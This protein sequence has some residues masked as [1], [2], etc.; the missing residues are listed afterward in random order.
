MRFKYYLR[1]IGIGILTATIILMIVINA[2][3]GI[4]TDEKVVKRATQLGYVLQSEEESQTVEEKYASGDAEEETAETDTAE[5]TVSEEDAAEDTSDNES[6]TEDTAEETA[7]EDTEED[8]TVHEESF[9]VSF[10][11]GNADGSETVSRNL[12][13]AGLID[14]ADDY[15]DYLIDNGYERKLRT[16][17]YTIES[18]LSYE[19]ITDILLRR[20]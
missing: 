8:T 1:G 13:E 20:N 17:T 18:G 14:D 6:E 4:M 19:E 12:Y 16:G 15:N 7:A 9:T 5:D 3:G 2:K 11:V 10:T